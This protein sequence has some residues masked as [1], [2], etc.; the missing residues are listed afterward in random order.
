MHEMNNNKPVTLSRR[1]F[2]LAASGTIGAS[3][4][5]ACG[6][7]P[8]APSAQPTEAPKPTDAP[9]TATSPAQPSIV[10]LDEF[11]GLAVLT[12]GVKPAR[13]F[14]T[15]EYD[16][17]KSIF[18]AAGVPTSPA[19]GGS[20]NLEAVAALKPTDIIGISIPTTAEVKDKLNALAKTTVVE[21]TAPWRD[22]LKTVGDA[23]GRADKAD[24]VAGRIDTALASLKSEI[25]TAGKAGSSVSVIGTLESQFFALAR[26]G[27][28]G[29]I[30][31]Q[32]GLK[33]PASQDIT[34][35]P[36]NPFVPISA[37]KL[38]EHDADFVMLFGGGAYD[39]KPLTSLAL[40]PQLTAVR[41][42]KVSEVL[43]EVWFMP[44][45]FGAD[46][47]IRDLRA[48]LLGD[49][50]VAKAGDVLSRWDAHM[51]GA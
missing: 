40:W 46:W 32:I 28:V 3:L 5:A 17:A 42:K 43:A 45:T 48:A 4:L 19:F 35:E 30:L 33:R 18:D 31:E 7:T 24:E 36:T 37:E 12:L 49:G 1:Q 10:A 6:A 9:A 11:M 13:V 23:L 44:N 2:L 15:F 41:D 22:Q 25:A 51:A 16:T 20:A 21:Y 38:T 34:T 27:L 39:P 50:T 47:I 14:L 8:A 26:S 29:S